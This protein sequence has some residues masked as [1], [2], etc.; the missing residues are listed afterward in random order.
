MPIAA[1]KSAKQP[2]PQ[3]RRISFRQNHTTRGRHVATQF[4]GSARH[5]ANPVRVSRVRK[6]LRQTRCVPRACLQSAKQASPDT[7]RTPGV[8][9]GRKTGLTRHAAHPVRVSRARK[10]RGT[11]VLSLSGS[12]PDSAGISPHHSPQGRAYCR[13]MTHNGGT[14]S[15]DTQR[16][17]QRAT[18]TSE[19]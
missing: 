4:R 1:T 17:T 11:L 8:S 6:R 7:L 9:H 16:L 14:Q 13:S 10:S 19:G 12:M 5:V 2:L 15:I 18:P 3:P